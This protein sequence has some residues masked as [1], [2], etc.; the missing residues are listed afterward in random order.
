MLDG[1]CQKHRV[2]G[3]KKTM[4]RLHQ[5]L[6]SSIPKTPKGSVLHQIELLYFKKVFWKAAQKKIGGKIASSFYENLFYLL[7]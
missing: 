5:E 4:E 6:K 2:S 7:F 1:L 3:D